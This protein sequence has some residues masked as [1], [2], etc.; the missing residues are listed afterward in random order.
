MW[1]DID[2]GL[3]EVLPTELLGWLM[4]MRCSL[5]PQQRLN[6]LSATGNSLKAED[7]EQALRGAEDDLRV[8]ESQAC[9]ERARDATMLVPTSGPSRVENGA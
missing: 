1:Q 6:V 5:S 9:A 7:I 2:S 3:P 4:L 8:Q